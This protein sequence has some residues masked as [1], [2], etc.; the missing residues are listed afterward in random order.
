MNP[1]RPDVAIYFPSLSIAKSVTGDLWQNI[2]INGFP[3]DGL[4]NETTPLEC[5]TCDTALIGL[6]F[7]TLHGP[8]PVW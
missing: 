1:S 7:N 4:H 8:W 6:C 3:A 2:L 5:P